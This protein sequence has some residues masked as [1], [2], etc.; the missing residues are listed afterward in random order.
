M[1]DTLYTIHVI[2]SDPD[3]TARLN[4]GAAQQDVS[5]DPVAWVWQNR[6]DLAAA[7]SWAEKVD[8]W[9]ASNPPAEG[10]PPSNDWAL[11]QAVISD[12]DIISQIQALLS[13]R[14]LTD[15]EH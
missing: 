11:D 8:Y 5:G 9:L 1:A 15:G 6:Y 14:G 4:A 13:E 3:F 12:A 7:P 10:E 2:A